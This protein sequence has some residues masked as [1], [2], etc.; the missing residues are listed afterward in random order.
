MTR[1]HILLI[2]LSGLISG[3]T[4]LFLKIALRAFPVMMVTD[5]RLG[6]SA[7]LLFAFA[8]VAAGAW[9]RPPTRWREMLAVATLGAVIPFP[10]QTWGASFVPSG[11]GALIFA[12]MP[13]IA[14]VLSLTL[15]AARVRY[16]PRFLIPSL[17]LGILGVAVLVGPEAIDTGHDYIIGAGL[18]LTSA[19]SNAL[20]A[21]ELRR[22]LHVEDALVLSAY[23][24]MFAAAM[25][26]P[27]AMISA[28]VDPP[29]TGSDL[30][31]ALGALAGLGFFSSGISYLIY[32]HLI[33]SAGP[34][35]ATYVTFVIPPIAV[36]LGALVLGEDLSWAVAASMALIFACLVL[37]TRSYKA[38]ARGEAVTVVDEYAGRPA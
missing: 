25:L 7:C 17:S 23:Q 38:A 34:T 11:T 12:M 33:V 20:G 3:T 22:R 37:L 32:T 5:I 18:L 8:R 30:L 19:F 13:V 28:L 16:N 24:L 27:L 36:L 1:R 26:S 2:C 4:F 21:V 14:A 10:L 9:P 15:G 29:E 31:P 6:V 35:A